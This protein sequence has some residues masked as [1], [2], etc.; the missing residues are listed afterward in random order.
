[1]SRLTLN[2]VRHA[3]IVA[4]AEA[5]L[6]VEVVSAEWLGQRCRERCGSED[7][8]VA[9]VVLQE[10]DRFT[11]KPVGSP[12]SKQVTVDTAGGWSVR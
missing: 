3:A 6:N 4:A 10:V 9:R 12:T 8:R 2:G 1:M 7:F 5:G 11:S